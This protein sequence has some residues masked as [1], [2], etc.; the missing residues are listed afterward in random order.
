MT[1]NIIWINSTDPSLIKSNFDRLL[2]T[3][4][5]SIDFEFCNQQHFT[6]P[7]TKYTETS[8]STE[9]TSYRNLGKIRR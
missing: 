4:S 8:V 7:Q 3:T 6:S 1:T 2:S 5:R 9:Y